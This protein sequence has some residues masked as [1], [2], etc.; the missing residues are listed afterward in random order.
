MYV[1][2]NLSIC[3]QL[4]LC[5]KCP[6]KPP[7]PGPRAFW[8]LSGVYGSRPPTLCRRRGSLEVLLDP[9]Q[10]SHTKTDGQHFFAFWSAM[11]NALVQNK[12]LQS[13]A[14]S[15]KG[16]ITDETGNTTAETLKHNCAC[17]GEELHVCILPKLIGT[18]S[19]LVSHLFV[20]FLVGQLFIGDFVSHLFAGFFREPPVLLLVFTESRRSASARLRPHRTE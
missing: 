1:Y 4:L 18:D 19:F 20:G 3:I 12:T 7:L 5:P 2:M 6:R 13:F 9:K 8:R 17:P 11:A 16:P 14:I 10:N 15:V